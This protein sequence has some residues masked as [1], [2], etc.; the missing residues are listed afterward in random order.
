MEVLPGNSTQLSSALGPKVV[1]VLLPPQG[2][3]CACPTTPLSP[4]QS[5]LDPSALAMQAKGGA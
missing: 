1:C 2:K 4:Q 5:A 3:F